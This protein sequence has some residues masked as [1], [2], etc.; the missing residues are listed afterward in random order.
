MAEAADWQF[1]TSASGRPYV[2]E[3]I[4]KAKLSAYELGQLSALMDRVARGEVLE[5]DTKYL[6]QYELYELRLFGANRSF[7]L[8]YAKRSDGRL[9]VAALFVAKKAQKLP[10]PDYEKAVGRVAGW[11]ARNPPLW[12]PS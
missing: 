4:Q 9:L 1:C 5:K 6:K 12:R 7:R 8:L 11:D 2:K 3:E 10:R